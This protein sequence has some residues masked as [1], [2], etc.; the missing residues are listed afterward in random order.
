MR[1]RERSKWTEKKIKT[2]ELFIRKCAFSAFDWK[3]EKTSTHDTD[4]TTQRQRSDERTALHLQYLQIKW[5]IYSFIRIFE[6]RF[7][8][9]YSPFFCVFKERIINIRTSN[10]S[11][12]LRDKYIRSLSVVRSQGC[13]INIIIVFVRYSVLST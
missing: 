9:V 4:A 12:Y 1:R 6:F 7:Q 13:Q 2:N 8:W 11:K 10:W 3:A 5:F